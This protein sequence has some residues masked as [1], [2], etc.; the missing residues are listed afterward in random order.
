MRVPFHA[1]SD[2]DHQC[3]AEHVGRRD[4]HAAAGDR[5]PP[6]SVMKN[7][8]R[9]APMLTVDPLGEQLRDRSVGHPFDH[10]AEYLGV[11]GDVVE[12]EAVLTLLAQRRQVL[13]QAVAPQ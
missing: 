6:G 11:G 8:S 9:S 4:A 10:P 13:V 5:F 1:P 12:V 2:R 3:E 7:A